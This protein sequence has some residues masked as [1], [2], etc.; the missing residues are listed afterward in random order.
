MA[1]QISCFDTRVEEFVD[2][3][4]VFEET[5]FGLGSFFSLEIVLDDSVDFSLRFNLNSLSLGGE[6]S[7][8]GDNNGLEH[9]LF[10]G[11]LLKI[12]KNANKL[13]NYNKN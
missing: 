6:G 3:D 10:L 7:D 8:S 5:P 4:N 11:I 13:T 12:Y 2:V 1:K 9:F